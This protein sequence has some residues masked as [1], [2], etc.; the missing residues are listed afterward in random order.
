M[1]D[2]RWAEFFAM[3]S[4]AGIYPKTL[5]YKAAYSLDF[6]PAPKP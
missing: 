3:A 5:D 6:V 2:A 1:T 4:E